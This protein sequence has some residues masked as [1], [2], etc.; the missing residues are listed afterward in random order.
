MSQDF[1]SHPILVNYEASPDGIVRHC[2]LKKPI[3]TIDSHGYMRFTVGG[4][5][6]LCHRIAYECHNGLIKDG[7][8]IDH[9]DSNPRNNSI[10]NLQ[11]ITQ[12]ENTKKERPANAQNTL[13]ASN[14][15]MKQRM[16]QRCCQA[17]GSRVSRSNN[18]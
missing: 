3:G 6:Y 13:R 15:L 2:R 7:S 4:K 9:I 16:K 18:R 5:S 14:H 17:A 8:V 12:S 11:C 1:K 10:S